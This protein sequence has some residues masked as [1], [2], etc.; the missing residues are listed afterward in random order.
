ME[1]NM[2]FF[3]RPV[4]FM[5]RAENVK[6]KYWVMRYTMLRTSSFS[7]SRAPGLATTSDEA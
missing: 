7:S 1:S 6:I 4:I 3:N 5:M 2:Y